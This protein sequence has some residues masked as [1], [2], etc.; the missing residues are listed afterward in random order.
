MHTRVEEQDP[1]AAWRSDSTSAGLQTQRLSPPTVGGDAGRP[2]SSR[3]NLIGLALIVL[4]LLLPIGRLL[5]DPGALTAGMILFTIAS[6]FLFVA[7]WRRIYAMLIP[8]SLLVGLSFGVPLA[9]LTSGISVLWGLAAGFLG[10]L[11]LGQMLFNRRSRWP[12]IPAIPLFLVGVIVAIA[13]L[14]TFLAGSLMVFPLLL[15]GAG[16][17]LGARRTS[18]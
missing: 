16:L 6:L 2:V 5:P 13:Q 18:F 12:V 3:N 15:I 1:E 7:F 9:D 10:I 8:G 14:P 4:G 11:F 17:F